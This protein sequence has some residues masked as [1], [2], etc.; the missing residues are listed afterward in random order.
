MKRL[1][2]LLAAILIAASTYDYAKSDGHY[3]LIVVVGVI[4]ALLLTVKAIE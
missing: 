1:F 3:G 2:V 4:A